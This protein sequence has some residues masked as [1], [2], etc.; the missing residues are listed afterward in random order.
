MQ[1][2]GKQGAKR[3]RTKA[4]GLMSAQHSLQLEDTSSSP[5]IG[6]ERPW[7]IFSSLEPSF[8][9]EKYGDK[10]FLHNSKN[11]KNSYF[12]FRAK[13]CA[14]HLTF[15][16]IYTSQCM[17]MRQVQSLPVLQSCD[18]TYPSR[19]YVTSAPCPVFFGLQ[20]GWEG[21]EGAVPTR[22]GRPRH[23]ERKLPS[24]SHTRQ[25][26]SQD[27]YLKPLTPSTVLLPLLCS[28]SPLTD[29]EGCLPRSQV[30]SRHQER[31]K[32][33]QGPG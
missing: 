29:I 2:R 9:P 5:P 3:Q 32:R 6:C 33:C 16:T 27:Q 7:P 19:V 1:G 25:E 8:P 10:M 23:R 18:L 31:R 28:A 20:E 14:K 13:P 4:A 22:D 26:Q 12:H 24:R 15:Y 21:P 17:S 11:M 30:A